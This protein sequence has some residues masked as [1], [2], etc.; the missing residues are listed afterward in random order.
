MYLE[1]VACFRFGLHLSEVGCMCHGLVESI[2]VGLHVSGVCY[3]Y[4]ES[5]ACIRV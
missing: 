3:M 4:Q 5:V 1:K 2:R